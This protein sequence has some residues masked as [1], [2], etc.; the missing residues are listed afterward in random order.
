MSMGLPTP[1]ADPNMHGG[2]TQPT[3]RHRGEG[4]E[5]PKPG[6]GKQPTT[7][8]HHRGAGGGEPLGGGGEGGGG[9]GGGT[10][11]PGSYIRLLVY[12]EP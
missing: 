10:A 5:P 7:T 4:G 9:G 1:Q 3:P 11:E 2:T 12:F 6:G 8:P